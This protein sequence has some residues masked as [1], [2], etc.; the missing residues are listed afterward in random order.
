M[1][2]KLMR[3]CEIII[4]MYNIHLTILLTVAKINAE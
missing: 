3:I 4:I 2:L 1:S